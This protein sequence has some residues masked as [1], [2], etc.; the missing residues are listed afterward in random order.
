MAWT[1]AQLDKLKEAYAHGIR[2]VSFGDRNTS[3]A[4]MAEMAEA[5]AR[6][7]TE[8]ARAATPARPRQYLGYT[9][10]GL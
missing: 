6:I 5:I 2:S 4:S 3:Y 10:K 9:R 7:E 8:L 1:Q